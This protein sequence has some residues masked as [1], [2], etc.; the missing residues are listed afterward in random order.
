MAQTTVIGGIYVEQRT[1][2][3]PTDAGPQP[4]SAAQM[5]VQARH[6]HRPEHGTADLHHAPHHQGLT[7][8]QMRSAFRV[9]RGSP[10]SPRR[11][12]RAAMSSATGRSPS[13]SGHRSRCRRRPVDRPAQ[14]SGRHAACPT[15][16]TSSRRGAVCSQT[17]PCPTVFD[18][19]GQAVASHAAQGHH[20]SVIAESRRRP[21]TKSRSPGIALSTAAP[22]GG[23]RKASTCRTRSTA[24]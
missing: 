20:R 19:I 4:D 18:D 8:M 22:T 16:I 21:T 24:G 23:T 14:F 12:R 1:D 10:C 7:E 15:C 17:N 6:G 11:L 9:P 2:D 13:V 5:A 3:R